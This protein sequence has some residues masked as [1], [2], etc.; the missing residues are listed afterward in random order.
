MRSDASRDRPGGGG[1]D[2]GPGLTG[3]ATYLLVF[4]A[5]LGAL[6]AVGQRIDQETGLVLYVLIPV[7]AAIAGSRAMSNRRKK[8]GRGREH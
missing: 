4:L 7:L 1:R 3:V 5:G 8:H 2:H 6:R